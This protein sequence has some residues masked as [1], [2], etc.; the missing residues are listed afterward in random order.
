[1]LER[2]GTEYSRTPLMR[3]HVVQENNGLLYL[4]STS[5]IITNIILKII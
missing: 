5:N 1:M 3:P 2:K 4:N